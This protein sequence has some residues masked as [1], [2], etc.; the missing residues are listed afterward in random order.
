MNDMDGTPASSFRFRMDRYRNV[1][2]PNLIAANERRGFVSIHQ[3]SQGLD[4]VGEYQELIDHLVD[5][6][7]SNGV[8]VTRSVADSRA[9]RSIDRPRVEA[10]F[11][12]LLKR[13]PS[14]ADVLRYLG[15][16]RLP[17]SD[18]TIAY[19]VQAFE[20]HTLS[21]QEEGILV[22]FFIS[23][24]D[25]LAFEALVN[26]NLINVCSIAEGYLGRGLEIDDL[27]QEGNIGLMYDV[28]CDN[29]A[30]LTE[31]G[32]RAALAHGIRTIVDLRKSDEVAEFPN[33]LRL[34]PGIRYANVSMVDPAVPRREFTTLAQD[35]QETLDT[36]APQVGQIIREVA[37]AG[38]GGILIHCVG[39][40]DRSGL[41]AG[42]LLRVAGVP[43]TVVAQDYAL[44]DELLR[45]LNEEWLANGPGTRVEREAQIARTRATPSVMLEVLGNLDRKYGGVAGYLKHTGVGAAEIE[46]VRDRLRE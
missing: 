4:F 3:L 13:L 6:L 18:D 14:T 20:L 36:F 34:V 5:A 44:S 25:Q 9:A 29:P 35:Y 17:L 19:V 40:K 2:L 33:P 8:R 30:R 28:R 43:V 26:D 41:I 45:P 21:R 42:L 23:E 32:C 10:T 38:D 11:S 31:A 27:I 1:Y 46:R 16:N 37:D 12:S 7:D 15:L 39:G 22:S 24:H